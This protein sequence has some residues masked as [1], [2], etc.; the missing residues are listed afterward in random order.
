MLFRIVSA[1]KN[2]ANQDHN[3]QRIKFLLEGQGR[4]ITPPGLGVRTNKQMLPGPQGIN[5]SASVHE[6]A[7]LSCKC[8]NRD[9]TRNSCVLTRN[10][11]PVSKG[12][13]S[14]QT[15]SQKFC[16]SHARV[17]LPTMNMFISSSSV[18]NN[19]KHNIII[20]MASHP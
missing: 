15:Y 8:I 14:V 5:P 1:M 9:K 7:P 10:N 17:C 13:P 4:K 18:P 20:I 6:F 2:A 19:Y 16:R 3:Q 12:K 11:S